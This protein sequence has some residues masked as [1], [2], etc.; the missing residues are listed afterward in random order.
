MADDLTIRCMV[1]GESTPFSVKAKSTKSV[2]DLKKAIKK[3]KPNDFGD[4][5]ADTLILWKVSLPN[6][7]TVDTLTLGSLPDG[8]T[9]LGEL[10]ARTLVSELFPK[11]QGVNDYIIVKPPPP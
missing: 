3:E 5:D 4:V 8:S 6:T 9:N 2:Y 11:G 1:D 10:N 7:A